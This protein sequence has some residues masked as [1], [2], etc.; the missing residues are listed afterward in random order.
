MVQ[1]HSRILELGAGVGL[2]SLVSAKLVA[3]DSAR[4]ES[5]ETSRIV[6]TDVDEK[7]LEM[8]EANIAESKCEYVF[9]VPTRG[10]GCSLPTA[11]G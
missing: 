8:L 7:V 3:R 2:L 9:L 11:S 1:L 4:A 10:P 5:G 6:A